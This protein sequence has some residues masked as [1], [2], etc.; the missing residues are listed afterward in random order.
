MALMSGERPEIFGGMREEV[1]REKNSAATRTAVYV[2][3]RR[4]VF[5]MRAQRPRRV[6]ASTPPRYVDVVMDETDKAFRFR[7]EIETP[8]HHLT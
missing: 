7:R 1:I 4:P 2:Q 6:G 3:T 5:T 8:S